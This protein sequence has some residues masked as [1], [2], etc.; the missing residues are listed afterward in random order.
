MVQFDQARDHLRQGWSEQFGRVLVD[1]CSYFLEEAGHV[2]GSKGRQ[3]REHLVKDAAEGPHVAL[4]V[5]GL[6]LPDFW[7]CV[8][9]SACLSV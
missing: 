8:V 5:V 1:S 6:V 4:G 2:F 7:A 3:Q 9:G